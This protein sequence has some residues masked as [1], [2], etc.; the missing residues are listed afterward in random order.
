M[1]GLEKNKKSGILC[2]SDC[3]G[4]SELYG[5]LENGYFHYECIDC[6]KQFSNQSFY[7][8]SFELLKTQYIKGNDQ[9]TKKLK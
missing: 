5:I 3:N 1:R 9:W 6:Y 8:G 4:K 2:C 7:T